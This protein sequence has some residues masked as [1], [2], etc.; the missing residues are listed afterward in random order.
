MKYV[1]KCWDK[2]KWGVESKDSSE[3]KTKV[4]TMSKNTETFQS[5]KP[6]I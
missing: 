4:V 6:Y 3:C 2:A 1:K 5:K